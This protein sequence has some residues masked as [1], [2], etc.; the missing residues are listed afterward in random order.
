MSGSDQNSQDHG[1]TRSIQ[2]YDG[3]SNVPVGYHT[4]NHERH[5]GSYYEPHIVN[6]QPPHRKFSNAL[7]KLV[8]I[9]NYFTTHIFTSRLN[10]KV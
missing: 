1:Q 9:I 6:Q 8:Q 2:H 10:S 4:W 3:V 5:Y 7:G